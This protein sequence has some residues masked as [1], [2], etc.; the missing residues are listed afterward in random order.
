MTIVE[1][2]FLELWNTELMY[3]GVRVNIFGIPRFNNH[4]KRTLNQTINRLVHKKM[5]HKNA[6][7]ITL[8]SAGKE[9]FKSRLEVLKNFEK[10]LD[11]NSDKKLL[12][13]FDIPENMK[14]HREWFRWHLKKFGYTMIQKSVWVGPDPLPK[15]FLLYVKEIN[16]ADCIKTF[17]L[18]KP[19][20]KK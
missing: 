9:Y 6:A 15:E 4:S 11:I 10:P 16:L 8:S 13:L 12:V 19:Y 20:K 2:I 3:K 18:A 7:G 14:S 17:K 5:I 1:E